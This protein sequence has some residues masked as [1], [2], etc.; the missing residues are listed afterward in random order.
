M[1]KAY[2]AVLAAA[3][4][5]LVPEGIDPNTDA[6][7]F[8]EFE[9]RFGA[10]GMIA[11]DYTTPSVK[12]GDLGPK[13]TTAAF[14]AEK[15]R[16]AKGFVEAC[17]TMGEELGKKL[18]ADA[19][20]P[21]QATQTDA[22]VSPAAVTKPVMTLDLRGVMCPINYVKTK[23]KLEMMEPGEVLEVWLDAG[24]PIKNVPQS[25]RNDGQNVISEVPA[26]SYY[27]VTVEKV[28]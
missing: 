9:R 2:R 23:L 28:V 16:Y 18:K 4:A 19:T 13:E 20:K 11:A 26:E 25:L 22:P 10:T 6:E 3:K 1:N 24:E 27:K 15:L 8:V 7:T 12:I 21:D 5:V 17:K 14:A